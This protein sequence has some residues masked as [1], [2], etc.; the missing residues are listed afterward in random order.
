MTITGTN[1]APAVYAIAQQDIDVPTSPG[2]LTA[3]IPVTFT[4]VDLTDLHAA[5]ITHVEAT[6]VTGSFS[7]TDDTALIALVQASSV[8]EPSSSTPGSFQLEFNANSSVFDYLGD[9]DIL[10]LTYTMEIDDLHGG[11]TPQTAVVAIQGNNG[12]FVGS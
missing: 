11:V 6:G 3:S 10:T 5:R 4:D 8:L 2:T 12:F 9:S 1:D 7:T